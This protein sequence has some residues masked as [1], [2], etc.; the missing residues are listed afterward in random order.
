MLGSQLM[1]VH[2]GG[3]KVQGA[4]RRL[5]ANCEP[6]RHA[7]Q[8]CREAGAEGRASGGQAPPPPPARRRRRLTPGARMGATKLQPSPAAH[9]QIRSQPLPQAAWSPSCLCFLERWVLNL[10]GPCKG[11][12]I[13]AQG[14]SGSLGHM[15]KSPWAPLPCRP[16]SPRVAPPATSSVKPAPAPTLSRP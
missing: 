10:Q 2:G 5:Y 1:H 7:P 15:L 8:Y 9:K 3:S 4:A 11:T 12:A 13:P 14:C 6:S 16:H